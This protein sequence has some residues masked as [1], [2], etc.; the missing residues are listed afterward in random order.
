MRMVYECRCVII[1]A[2]CTPIHRLHAMGLSS[3]IISHKAIVSENGMG[4]LNKR[5]KNARCAFSTKWNFA[6]FI[7]RIRKENQKVLCD[8]CK[9]ERVC[10]RWLFVRMQN[11]RA[12]KSIIILHNLFSRMTRYKLR[13]FNGL[14]GGGVLRHCSNDR[15]IAVPYTAPECWGFFSGQ[16]EKRVD[17]RTVEERPSRSHSAERIFFRRI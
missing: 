10:L 8:L 15:V 2:Q 7:A 4:Y 17:C 12:Y 3:H 9:C 14:P 11:I 16:I 6:L 1:C 13:M 5:Q